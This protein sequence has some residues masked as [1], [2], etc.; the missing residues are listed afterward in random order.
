M[1][2]SCERRLAWWVAPAILV[3]PL[4]RCQPIAVLRSVA[5]TAGPGLGQIF[6]E[7]HVGDVMEMVVD[8]PVLADSGMQVGWKGLTGGP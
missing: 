6:T 3:A 8:V 5:L 4:V 7:G 1:I 2:R